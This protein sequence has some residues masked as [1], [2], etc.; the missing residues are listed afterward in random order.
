MRHSK[1][2]NIKIQKMDEA[3]KTSVIDNKTKMYVYIAKNPAF[4]AYIKIGITADLSG[5]KDTLSNTSVPE[6]FVYIAFFECEDAKK[7]EKTLHETFNAHRHFTETGRRTEFFSA[8]ILANVLSF[9]RTS[10]SGVKEITPNVSA[11]R[12]QRTT[13]AMLGIPEGT[14]IYY[15]NIKTEDYTGVVAKNNKVKYPG[16]KH[17]MTVS[18]IATRLEGSPRNGYK[19]FYYKNKPLED[20]RPTK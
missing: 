10:L 6:D 8:D 19:F 12:R 11:K 17:P 20:F 1:K 7:T 5:R 9:A 14:E 18:D 3:V 15:K 4:P 13:F 2:E 16:F